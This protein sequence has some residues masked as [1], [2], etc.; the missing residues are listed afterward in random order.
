MY[1][2]RNIGLRATHIVLVFM[3]LVFA[4]KEAAADFKPCFEACELG[5]F[6]EKK[7]VIVCSLLCLVQ[8]IIKDDGHSVPTA[9]SYCQSGCAVNHC[10]NFGK[11]FEKTEK[12]VASCGNKCKYSGNSKSMGKSSSGSEIH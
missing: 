12:C 10:A 3:F 5:C 11:D 2:K 4:I 8:C 7:P 9:L 1:E 6:V